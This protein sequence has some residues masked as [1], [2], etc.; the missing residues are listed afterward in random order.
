MPTSRGDQGAAAPH[1]WVSPAVQTGHA[2]NGCVVR[3]H[4]DVSASLTL[5]VPS[6]KPANM[7]GIRQLLLLRSR[8]PQ[9]SPQCVFKLSGIVFQPS[10][11]LGLVF[12]TM[13]HRCPPLWSWDHYNNLGIS[14]ILAWAEPGP[15]QVCTARHLR[16][17]LGST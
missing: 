8:A 17:R 16:L 10:S 1:E 13:R 2:C 14:I 3:V 4:V 11:L 7:D 12:V 15:H 6:W 5:Q 9:H